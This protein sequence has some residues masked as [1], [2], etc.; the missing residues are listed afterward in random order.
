MGVDPPPFSPFDRIKGVK[1]IKWMGSDVGNR[2]TWA[3]RGR[4]FL[5]CARQS[6]FVCSLPVFCGPITKNLGSLSQVFS[7]DQM[8]LC[9]LSSHGFYRRTDKRIGATFNAHKNVCTHASTEDFNIV[10]SLHRHNR[11]TFTVEE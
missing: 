4:L 10:C 1:G 2:D 5:A 7:L 3:H 6:V 9:R 8:S 11:C